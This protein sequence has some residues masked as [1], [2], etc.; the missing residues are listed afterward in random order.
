MKYSVI[1]ID[2]NFENVKYK[3]RPEDGDA[4]YTYGFGSLY[5]RQFKRYMPH[6]EV[7]CWKADRFATE[8][9]SRLIQGVNHII[10]P[11]AKLGRA[12][13]FSGK[14]LK[15]AKAFINQN[16][17]MVF[18]VSGFDHL[19]HFQMSLLGR[20][21]PVFVQ[22]H[23]ES[24]AV[25]KIRS[26]SGVKFIYW[27]L[28]SFIEKS[29]LNRTHQVYLLDA[30]AG[31]Y[32]RI[33]KSRLKVSTTG[34]DAELFPSID[35]KVAREKLGLNQD[36][37]YLLF[38]GRLNSS[39]RADMLISA[40]LKLKVEFPGLELLIG[41]CSQDDPFFRMARDAGAKLTGM[42]PQHEVAIWLSAAN[43][44][45]LPLLD[46]AHLFGGLGMLPVQSM[47]CN[48]PVVG[49]TL[50]CFPAGDRHKVGVFT[51]N[52]PDLECALRDILSGKSTFPL[53]RDIALKYYS[54]QS[55]SEKTSSD[56]LNA[57]KT[58]CQ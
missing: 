1:Y 49:S 36:A 44:Y 24:P 47:L 51:D 5:A 11:A 53:T 2:Y 4:Y 3:N 16:P 6:W 28:W 35:K 26:S 19:L 43:A 8:V 55:I 18:N 40:Y 17:S 32:L 13:F 10:F 50:K 29:A 42:I 30:E 39:K 54:W 52:Q 22:H 12:G 57:I 58:V 45:S 31:N 15:H 25:H 9:S 23:G 27:Y 33:N 20:K 48:T 41:G 46:T 14:M 56:Y 21:C 7:Q 34:V 37:E 38:I